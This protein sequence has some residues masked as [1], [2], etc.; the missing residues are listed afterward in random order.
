MTVYE[1]YCHPATHDHGG[2]RQEVHD[3]LY[4]FYCFD[5]HDFYGVIC[6]AP[7]LVGEAGR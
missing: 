7:A 5:K 3:K 2:H 1:N 4:V 6:Q